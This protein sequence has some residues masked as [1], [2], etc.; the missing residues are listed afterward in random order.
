MSRDL[1]KFGEHQ[2][3]QDAGEDV[4]PHSLWVARVHVVEVAGG[5]QEFEEKLDDP[6]E[7]VQLGD[8]LRRVVLRGQRGHVE[9]VGFDLPIVDAD[10]AKDYGGVGGIETSVEVEG[11]VLFDEAE[12]GV[13]QAE[14]L[15]HRSYRSPD[16]MANI[17]DD[18]VRVT[19][20]SRHQ[21]GPAGVDL[22]EVFVAQVAKIRHV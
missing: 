4:C 6:P 21:V 5:F 17:H 18:G 1:T 8:V 10:D 22:S 16:S 20:E 3:S 12:I 2:R 19:L 13:V 15:T 9:V 7:P 14:A 11:L